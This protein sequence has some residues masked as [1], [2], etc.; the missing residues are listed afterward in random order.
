MKATIRTDEH[1]KVSVSKGNTD[2]VWFVTISICERTM[3]IILSGE[4][5]KVT[6]LIRQYNSTWIIRK[7]VWK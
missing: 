4:C 6:E 2:E 3:E 1:W 5:W 7:I